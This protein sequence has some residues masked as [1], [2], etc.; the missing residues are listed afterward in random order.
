M[1]RTRL[2]YPLSAALA[3]A[4]V[5]TACKKPEPTPPRPPR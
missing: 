5:L 2:L 3:T 4:L 1:S